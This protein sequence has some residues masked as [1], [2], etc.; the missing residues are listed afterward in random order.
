MITQALTLPVPA[1]SEDARVT[2]DDRLRE[3]FG[4]LF[5]QFYPE[6]CNFV[7]HLV[8]SR[9]VAEELVQDLFLR[10]WQRRRE[11]ETVLPSRSYLYQAAWNRAIDHLKHERVVQQSASVS[12]VEPG[13][14]TP[15]PDAELGGE[16]L[17]RQPTGDPP[18]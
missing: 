15:L 16:K 12:A 13:Q 8:R 4:A 17:E 1:R 7:V 10:L 2:D 11:W 14:G 9:A 3:R 6:L 18:P 5:R